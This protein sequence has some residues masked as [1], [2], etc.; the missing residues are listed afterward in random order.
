MPETAADND[1]VQQVINEAT[2]LLQSLS[3][4]DIISD[5]IAM[6]ADVAASGEYINSNLE[7]MDLAIGNLFERDPVMFRAIAERFLGVSESDIRD[8]GIRMLLQV[9][10]K[11]GDV[12]TRKTLESALVANYSHGEA[13]T[14]MLNT[15]ADGP[16]AI[17]ELMISL[18]LIY[19]GD[20]SP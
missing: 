6:V 14:L 20:K 5:R 1:P 2:D 16:R 3:L 12:E 9:L 15:L 4:D 13:I 19:N 10:V 7:V 11:D 18:V 8:T 17:V